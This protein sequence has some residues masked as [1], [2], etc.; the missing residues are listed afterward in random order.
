MVLRFFASF[1]MLLLAGYFWNVDK[2]I[3]AILVA[4][5]VALNVPVEED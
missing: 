4:I 2:W 3:S 1:A 5:V